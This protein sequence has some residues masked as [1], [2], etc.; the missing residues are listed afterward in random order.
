M[1]AELMTSDIPIILGLIGV[2]VLGLFLMVLSGTRMPE[3]LPGAIDYT[4][5]D[6]YIIFKTKRL[7]KGWRGYVFDKDGNILF[8]TTRF[9]DSEKEVIFLIKNYFIKEWRILEK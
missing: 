1:I 5:T 6:S 3:K 8:M 2:L 7:K 4:E 9:Y